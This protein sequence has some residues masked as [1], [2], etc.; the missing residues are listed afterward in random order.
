MTKQDK[1]IAVLEANGFQ[2]AHSWEV[3]EGCD[4]EFHAYI[5]VKRR[6]AITRQ[7]QIDPNGEVNGQEVNVYLRN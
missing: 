7:A 3:E 2:D 5:Y 6:G 1:A 4:S